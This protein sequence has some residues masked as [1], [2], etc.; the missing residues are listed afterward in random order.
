VPPIAS[1]G[2]RLSDEANHAGLLWPIDWGAKPVNC[3]VHTCPCGKAVDAR[4]CCRSSGP[5]HQ[6]HHQMNDVV[7]RTIKRAQISAAKDPFSLMQQDGKRPDGTTLLPW[8]RGKSMA[9]DVTVPD[10][11][12]ESHIDQ[13]ARKAAN[14]TVKYGAMSVSHIFFQWQLRLLAPGTSP[15]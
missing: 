8:V 3:T 11:Y 7:W 15:P 12:A 6:S 14:K 4:L 10:T 5:R 9:W 1:V 2:F 13:T